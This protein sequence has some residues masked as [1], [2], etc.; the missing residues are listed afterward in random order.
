MKKIALLIP[1]AVAMLCSSC[2]VSGPPVATYSGVAYIE[3]QPI[4]RHC[5][6]YYIN[7]ACTSSWGFNSRSYNGYVYPNSSSSTFMYNRRNFGASVT[8]RNNYYY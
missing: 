1:V 6:P 5:S 3:P 8:V 7:P 2:V 4:Y